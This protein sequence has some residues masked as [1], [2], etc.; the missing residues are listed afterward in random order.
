MLF[1]SLVVPLELPAPEL[2]VDAF[3]CDPSVFLLLDSLEATDGAV[4]PSAVVPS[5]VFVLSDVWLE[6]SAVRFAVCVFSCDLDGVLLLDELA[7]AA[8][9]L[10]SATVIVLLRVRLELSAFEF[11]VD[12]FS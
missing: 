12:A 7:A 5:V 1:A 6:L 3:S 2:A 10:V 8:S 11:T 4:V 9:S